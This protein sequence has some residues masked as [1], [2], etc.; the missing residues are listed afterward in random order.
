MDNS[1]AFLSTSSQIGF[2]AF[3]HLEKPNSDIFM[4]QLKLLTENT[5]PPP[6]IKMAPINSP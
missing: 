2:P 3:A 4:L 5:A 6:P 1:A